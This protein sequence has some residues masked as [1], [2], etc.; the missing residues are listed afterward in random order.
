MPDDRYT[1]EQAL[2]CA[3]EDWEYP[4]RPDVRDACSVLAA[5]VERVRALHAPVT[6]RVIQPLCAGQTCDHDDPDECLTTE[7]LCRACATIASEVDDTYYVVDEVTWPCATA[8]ALGVA[9]GGGEQD[10]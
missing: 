4:D 7:V 8:R 6:E 9:P 5:A 10:A 1:V 3:R 2:A